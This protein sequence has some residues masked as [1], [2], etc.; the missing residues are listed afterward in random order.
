MKTGALLIA[1]LNSD[2]TC[3]GAEEMTAFFPMLSAGGTTMIKR[4]IATLRKSGISPII[5]LCG[6]QKELLKNHL[7][8]NNV[9]FCEDEQFSSHS[10]EE[11]TAVGLSFA[12]RY[13]DRV[14]IVPVEVP[15]FSAD[16]VSLLLSCQ[17]N[18]AP[19]FQGR[20]GYPRLIYLQDYPE[21]PS[22]RRPEAL[23]RT[24]ALSP[25][26][27]H[28]PSPVQAH[29]PSPDQTLAPS[30]VQA[31]AP[32]PD[33]AL[34]PSPDRADISTFSLVPTEDPG[35]LYSL[36]DADGL[37]QIQ[38]Y[39]KALRDTND[40]RLKLK[41][42]LT[43]EEDFFG[44]G[45]W[46]LLSLIDQTGSIQS[47]AAAMK[48]SYSKSWK[49]IN[50]LE[51]QMGFAFLNRCNGGKNGGNSTLTEKGRLFIDKYQ[52]LTTDLNQMAQNFFD[53]YFQDFQ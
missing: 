53:I 43:K 17:E 6:Y 44:P 23:S 40:L 49:L 29:V 48:M 10:R 20:T 51:Q 15:V 32:S 19:V 41:V 24:D 33:Q 1:S 30:P 37:E 46:Q 8:H 4:E 16:T 14:L 18:T 7:S 52:A 36:T 42:T 31:H 27:M 28:A 34:A 11:T 22:G 35:V 12:A 3:K 50:R 5:V 21:A 47:A 2:S 26:Q 25:D 13:C 9:L 38:S 39:I 45:T